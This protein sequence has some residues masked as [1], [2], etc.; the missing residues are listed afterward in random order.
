MPTSLHSVLKNAFAL[1]TEGAAEPG[2]VWHTPTLA[3][4][5]IDGRPQ[6]RSV[7]LRRW[8]EQE[9]CLDIHTDTRSAKYAQLCGQPFA[10]L[11]GWDAGRRIQL[12]IGGKVGLHV[13]DGIAQTAWSAL[14]P[15]SRATYAVL[16]GPGTVLADPCKVADADESSAFAVFCVVRLRCET[17]EWLHLEQGSHRRALFSWA[18][19][20]ETPMWLSP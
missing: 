10:A 19:G 6:L 3:T 7:I 15:A 8:S 20:A 9:R 5:G 11:Q 14:R 18:N 12:R 2:S 16:P 13:A 4:T 1:L 17:L